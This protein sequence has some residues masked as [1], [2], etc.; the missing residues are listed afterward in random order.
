M[1]WFLIS[2][3]LFVSCR[4]EVFPGREQC[5]VCTEVDSK[6]NLKRLPKKGKDCGH[7][8]H[9]DC[10]DKWFE[11]QQEKGLSPT[12]PECRMKAQLP[13][14][15]RK[16]Q[17][18]RHVKKYPGWVGDG[19]KDD[20]FIGRTIVKFGRDDSD[21]VFKSKK[22]KKATS[23]SYHSGS[24]ATQ[25]TPML[26]LLRKRLFNASFRSRKPPKILPPDKRKKPA[27]WVVTSADFG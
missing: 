18:K 27:P 16:E 1:K 8:V 21:V 25:L 4:S 26:L 11:A 5:S 9:Y 7:R 6:K 20:V 22:K 17:L 15:S 2:F 13:L 10:L 23:F 24:P 19:S 3:L 14:L 12:C